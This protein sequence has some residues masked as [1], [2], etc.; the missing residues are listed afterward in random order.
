[1]YVVLDYII[2]SDPGAWYGYMVSQLQSKE[3][4]G[5]DFSS[6]CCCPK[7]TKDNYIYVYLKH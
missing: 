6:A 3:R 4:L 5:A 7:T 1:M 2:K